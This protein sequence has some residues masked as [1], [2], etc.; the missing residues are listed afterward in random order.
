MDS[1]KVSTEA[2][3]CV[4]R[5]LHAFEVPVKSFSANDT[6]MASSHQ[7]GFL[8]NSSAGRKIFPFLD[9][10]KNIDEAP[11]EIIWT[12][13][14][15]GTTS[16]AKWYSSNREYRVTGSIGSFITPDMTGDLLVF[17]WLGD[18]QFEIA[19]FE[20]EVDI[21]YVRREL[22]VS[23]VSH[24]AIVGIEGVL[25]EREQSAFEEYVARVRVFPGTAILSEETRRIYDQVYNQRGLVRSNPDNRLV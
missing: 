11:I 9:S 15:E 17:M 16:K 13:T 6:G 4:A 14:G 12:L 20:R 1:N 10:S 21:E 2:V 24:G 23:P 22:M 19:T 18:G 7:S 3:T 25:R 5:A 8:V